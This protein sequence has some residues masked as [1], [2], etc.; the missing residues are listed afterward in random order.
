M[1]REKKYLFSINI[2]LDVLKSFNL[3]IS[4]IF[5]TLSILILL[6][7]L[8]NNNKCEKNKKKRQLDVQF[9][10]IFSIV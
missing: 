3:R 7:N 8:V 2:Y 1:C 10:C 6:N 9:R 4:I 5:K